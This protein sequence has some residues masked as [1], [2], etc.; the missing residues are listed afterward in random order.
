MM[1]KVQTPDRDLASRLES[2]DTF[3]DRF[4]FVYTWEN[5]A[6]CFQGGRL[7]RPHKK[8]LKV[9]GTSNGNSRAR[10]DESSVKESE[11]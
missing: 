3:W 10:Q 4:E 5:L 8:R 9:S 6:S 7:K 2:R 11:T 1:P